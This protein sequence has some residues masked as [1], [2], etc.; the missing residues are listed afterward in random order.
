MSNEKQLLLD[1]I[2]E[3]IEN[4]SSFVIMQYSSI[5]ANKA[6]DLRTSIA[7]LGGNVEIVRKRVLIKAAE[8][9]GITL[10][11]AQLPGHIGLV[12]AGN[13]PIETTKTVAQFSDAN[14]KKIK[15]VGGRFEGQ[16]YDGKDMEKLSKL[17]GKNEMR[18]Q[19][20]AT[21]VAAPQSV[22]SVMNNV[23]ASVVYCLDNKVKKED[24]SQS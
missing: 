19:L 14:E 13:D 15:L 4:H 2:K 11:L 1:E 18:A 10:D 3:Q 21:F 7:K 6:N 9:A 20:L 12:F 5:T 8:A 22:L 23:I 24:G 17:P 16:L